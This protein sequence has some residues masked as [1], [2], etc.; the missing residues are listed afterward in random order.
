MSNFLAIATA[1][2]TLR[3][4]LDSTVGN[5]VPGA[6]ATAAKPSESGEKAVNIYLYQVGPNASWRNDDLPSRRGD[7]TLVQRPRAA[8]DLYY[9]LTFY[10]DEAHQEPQRI[11]GSV[12]ST[13]HSRPVLSR[14]QIRE[15][16]SHAENGFLNGSDLA[17]EI[18]LVR[19]TPISLSLE[20]LNNLWSGFFQIPYS[21]SMAYQA[22]VVFIEGKDIAETPLPVLDRNLYVATMRQPHIEEVAP[23]QGPGQPI[24][25][26]SRVIVKG[27]NLRGDATKVLISGKQIEPDDIQE[28]RIGL[29]LPEGL[30]ARIQSLQ[31]VHEMMMGTPPEI[32]RGSESNVAAFLLRPTIMLNS[33][34][35][36]ISVNPE[37]GKGQ[38]A[39]LFLNEINRTTNESPAAYTIVIPIDA[40][41]S[42]VQIPESEIKIKSGE[43][44][45]RLGV[46]GANSPLALGAVLCIPEG[47][48]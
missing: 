47:G 44:L 36:T 18:E 19:F 33:D 28:N 42:S 27:R 14:Q 15:A 48:G 1:T 34:S 7:K 4:M 2:E 8:L 31:V 41:T 5:D 13:L 30:R 32:H 12:I 22:S 45:V 20:E 21:L 29:N 40:A 39:V 25:A 10:G 35:K 11:M 16:I 38:R 26:N 3:Q 46:D 43:Y 6:N 37:I 23:D 9:L 24:L 17:E